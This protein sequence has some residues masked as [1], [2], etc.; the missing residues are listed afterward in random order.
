M[1]LK[2]TLITRDSKNKCRVLYISCDNEQD[3]KIYVIKRSSGLLGGKLI[4]QPEL[5]ITK[6]KVKRTTEQQAVLQYNALIK[7]QL[8]KGYKQVSTLGIDDLTEETVNKVLPT[9]K[10]DQNGALKPML[11][12]VLDKNNKA[13]TDKK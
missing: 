1:K 7:K 10:T 13:L 12:K 3:E 2:E 8:D 5:V 9:N 11:C 4:E 6:G